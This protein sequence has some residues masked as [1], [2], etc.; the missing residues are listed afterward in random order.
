MDYSVCYLGND[1]GA[2]YAKEQTSFRVFAP[3]AD[4][5]S[6]ILYKEGNGGTAYD[7][8]EMTKDV[9]GTWVLSIP[10]D[11]AG[12]YYCYQ[13]DVNGKTNITQDPYAKACGVNGTRSMVV[14]LSLTNPDGFEKDHGPLVKSPTDVIVCEISIADTTADITSNATYK[15]KYLGMTERGLKSAGGV[16]TGLDH[17][18]DLGVTHLQIMP[19][20]DFGSIDEA[21][22]DVEQYNW[23]Y[24]PV[25]Y[26]VPEGSYSMD[27]FH[28]EVRIKEYK[29]MVQAIHE[30]GMG[31]IM[32]VVYNH[33]YDADS[34][35]FE[36]IVPG[37]YYR[38]REDG[39]YS[40]ASACGNEIA[41]DHAMVRKYIIDSVRYWVEEY[42]IDG[43]RF[44]L[45]GVLDVDTMNAVYRELKAIRPDIIIY[46]EGWTGGDS[47]LPVEQ[48]SLKV[49]VSKLEGVGV[50]SDDIRDGVRGHVFY[51]ERK[52]FVNGGVNMANDIK[53]S[54]VGAVEHPEVDYKSY[55][56]TT[57]G[58]YAKSP[59]D[60]VNYASCH[61]NLTLW[62]KLTVSRPDASK[63]DKLK[64]NRLA[65]CIVFTS[66][67]IP[68][69]LEGEEFART[70][71][72][73][74]SKD[75]SENSYNLPLYTNSL[76]YDR[77]EEFLELNDFYKGLIA[78]RK[79]FEEFRLDT[80]EAVVD[81]LHFVDTANDNVV[82]YTITSRARTILVCMNANTE[83]YTLD[84]P[85]G[86][87]DVYV[88]AKNASGESL[89]KKNH[90]TMVSA[91]SCLVA[92]QAN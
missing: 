84:L 19:S 28:G 60:V 76:K 86:E 30:A 40:D 34:S 18:V 35:C 3:T 73:K 37:Y 90:Q 65:A 5:V 59:K 36:K 10:G 56:Y 49:N 9:E 52:G 63:E 24:D 87:W 92:V 79:K 43:F 55:S 68:F 8:R 29:Q 77:L 72:V 61:D 15:G 51:E 48:R 7:T 69:F 13:V 12:V 91:I 83:E 89:Y 50:F 27:P 85:D 58:A 21:R 88:D 31:V 46:G 57:T 67:G 17:F 11:L 53:F 66:Q 78:L 82:I 75:V 74:D 81:M 16:P 23:G 62:D 45:M 39:S 1:M 14:D 33:T 44:D 47:T 22:L 32:D 80:R 38:L 25:N 41:S 20:Y 71:P 6:V 4:Q 26:N 42:H 64:M 70:K 2:V 54:I